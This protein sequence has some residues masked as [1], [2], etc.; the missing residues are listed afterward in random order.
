MRVYILAITLALSTSSAFAVSTCDTLPN[1]KD[2]YNCWMGMIGNAM[3][4]AD[5]YNTAVMASPKVPD[6]IKGKVSTEYHSIEQE[7]QQHCKKN[8]HRCRVRQYDNFN[9]F[10]YKETS[11]YGV[12][13]KRLD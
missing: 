3:E 6:S 1:K 12:P 9:E 10:A 13:D 2:S 8:D 11:K 4:L 7:A 5:E